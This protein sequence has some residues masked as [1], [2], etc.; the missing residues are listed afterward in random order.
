MSAESVAT[1]FD[2][3]VGS[4]WLARA[5]ADEHSALIVALLS[6]F[7]HDL[8]TPLNTVV[9]WTHLMQ[10]GAVEQSRAKHVADVLARATREQ[11]VMLD[12]FI[13][14]AR[15]ILGVLK[16]DA[17]TLPL[18][19]LIGRAVERASPL[20]SLHAISADYTPI[21]G[22]ATV[23][24]DERRL[25]RLFYRLIAAVVRR[26]REGSAVQIGGARHSDR[27]QL[28]ISVTTRGGDWAE[29]Q[30]L[31]L[32]ISAYVVSLHRG[33]LRAESDGERATL[34]LDLPTHA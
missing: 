11:T 14:D 4:A 2:A 3:R 27:V 7:N 29:P 31:D 23:D 12:E 30:L 33:E 20:F 16:I 13:D 15:S 32:R 28:R 17:A 5:S 8:R 25:T 1:A 9:G 19:E 22:E 24:G 26:A 21:G 6:R 34:A 10:Q 18:D